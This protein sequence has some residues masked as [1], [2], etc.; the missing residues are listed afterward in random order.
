MKAS[1]KS[2]K[3]KPKHREHGLV[4]WVTPIPRRIQASPHIR[5]TRTAGQARTE[6]HGAG[7]R[8]TAGCVAP[9]IRARVG[10]ANG[11]PC[12]PRV[13]AEVRERCLS[14][15][16]VRHVRCHSLQGDRR[17]L[18]RRFFA[19]LVRTQHARGMVEGLPGNFH[20]IEMVKQLAAGDHAEMTSPECSRRAG[21]AS[22][23]GPRWGFEF[24]NS[25]V[26]SS[27]FQRNERPS[28]CTG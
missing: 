11:P 5:H 4:G 6:A 16:G 20:W 27:A 23:G 18:P 8:R 24:A 2:S 3:S 14:R 21:A 12:S 10:R 28:T 22:D 26:A 25:R 17:K 13:A 15:P 19:A 7:L 9:R 1:A